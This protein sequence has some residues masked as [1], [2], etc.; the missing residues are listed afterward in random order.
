MRVASQSPVGLR[1]LVVP[2]ERYRDETAE[3]IKP[4][5]AFRVDRYR[6]RRQPNLQN[7][8]DARADRKRQRECGD[9]APASGNH[10]ATCGERAPGCGIRTRHKR[11]HRPPP[12]RRVSH[13]LEEAPRRPQHGARVTVDERHGL[14]GDPAENRGVE[15]VGGHH[16]LSRR[17]EQA[18]LLDALHRRPP[19]G[20]RIDDSARACQRHLQV[21]FGLSARHDRDRLD[22]ET[23]R[24]LASAPRRENL[25]ESA[26]ISR[27]SDEA[28][29]HDV[30]DRTVIVNHG[31]YECGQSGAADD[32]ARARVRSG[33]D[34]EAVL[35]PGDVEVRRES[36]VRATCPAGEQLP[37]CEV[38]D[39]DGY[40]GCLKQ[41]V[42]SGA[43]LGRRESLYCDVAVVTGHGASLAES[44]CV[45]TR[46]RLRRCST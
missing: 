16:L 19:L 46:Y 45:P 26:A 4:C 30:C 17:D 22:R 40:T 13:H 21:A 12:T 2:F 14:L 6:R 15:C 33:R 43:P 37:R 1:S 36:A 7:P 28:A 27:R 11:A 35:R 32:T 42:S 24:V 29:E 23:H 44:R 39:G 38:H 3:P 9:A 34:V 25:P 5:H 8:E 31:S 20:G 18:Q 10:R 41:R